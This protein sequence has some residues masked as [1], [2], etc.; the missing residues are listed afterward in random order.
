MRR[1]DE[2]LGPVIALVSELTTLKLVAP[3]MRRILTTELEIQ[4]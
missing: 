3:N 1:R 4:Y 2:S